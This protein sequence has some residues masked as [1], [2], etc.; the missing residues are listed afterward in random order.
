[1]YI[2]D[3]M[4]VSFLNINRNKSKTILNSLS[5]SIA[6][7]SIIL[8]S[9]ISG[10]GEKMLLKEMDKLGLQGIS[11][12]KNTEINSSPLYAEDVQRLMKRFK[13]IS[14]AS[15]IVMDYGMCRFNK[16][17]SDAILFGVGEGANEIYDV[18][19]IC[20]KVPSEID[21]MQNKKVAV[22]DDELAMRMYHR[23]NVVGKKLYISTN[24]HTEEFKIIGVIESQKDGINKL[25]GNNI[26]DFVY[27]PYSTLNELRNSNEISQ[28]SV[29]CIEGKETDGIEFVNYLSNVKSNPNGYL[30][31]NLSNQM[32]DL[33]KII[34][35]V[36]RILTVIGIIALLVAGFGITNAMI[37]TIDER[38]KEIGI[39]IAIGA[40]KSNIIFCFLGESFLTFVIGGFIGATVSLFFI[41]ILKFMF[42]NSFDLH[43]KYFFIAETIALFFCILFSLIPVMKVLK[44]NPIST[45][46]GNT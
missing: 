44:I 8:V 39:S 29:R 19:I 23:N 42:V 11:I 15:P 1:M 21:I 14:K 18:N 37:S 31:E 17:E 41:L 3:I 28:I 26:P 10:N 40:K 5:I 43:I 27:L 12:Y 34:Q 45:L 32:H 33:R 6:V 2:R 36:S 16:K 30:V 22:V 4:K 7:A 38:R 46:R 35:L 20:G 13:Y 9:T 24:G 25:L